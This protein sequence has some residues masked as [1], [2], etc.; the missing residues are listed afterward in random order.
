MKL[1]QNFMKKLL[2]FTLVAVIILST[3]SQTFAEGVPMNEINQLVKT[4]LAKHPYPPND[5][6][7]EDALVTSPEFVSLEKLC[8]AHWSLALD[9]FDS[10]PG[11]DAGKSMLIAAFQVLDAKNYMTALERLANKFRKKQISKSV[12]NSALRPIPTGRMQVFLVDN[13]KHPRVQAL[14]KSLRPLFEGD[15]RQAWIDKVLSGEAKTYWND[16]RYDYEGMSEGNIPEVLLQDATP[17][18]TPTPH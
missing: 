6:I 5:A 1:T 8:K 16:W 13:Y 12:I 14:L 17:T 11:D 4:L 15:A 9:H 10:I 18:S 7:M 3:K 2:L